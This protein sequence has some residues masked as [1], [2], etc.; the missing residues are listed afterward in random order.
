MRSRYTCVLHTS[1]IEGRILG[2][3]GID[4]GSLPARFRTQQLV[5]QSVH[6]SV[7]LPLVGNQEQSVH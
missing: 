4:H 2:V 3:F 1:L 6:T 5:L 7:P